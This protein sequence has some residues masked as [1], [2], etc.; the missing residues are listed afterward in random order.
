MSQAHKG[1]EKAKKVSSCGSIPLDLRK[2]PNISWMM[3]V[4][5]EE[6]SK[7]QINGKAESYLLQEFSI[8]SPGCRFSLM[9]ALQ[10][11]QQIQEP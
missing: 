10:G 11:A 6:S 1:T 9:G 3:E 4:S 5:W 7:L 2:P 8:E